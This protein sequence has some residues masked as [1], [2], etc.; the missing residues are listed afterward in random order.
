MSEKISVIIPAYNVEKYIEMCIDSL[1]QQT[2]NDLEIVVIN[3]GSSDKTKE[4]LD[5]Y[6]QN[7]AN[8]RV[9]HTENRGVSCA[10]NTGLNIANGKYVMFL[11]A[12]DYL[13]QNAIEIL[14]Q[15]ALNNDADIVSGLMCAGVSQEP[16]SITDT[17]VEIWSNTEALQKSLEDN[18]F[19]YSSCAKL[20]KRHIVEDVRFVE[21]RKI[22][23]DSYFVFSTFLKNPKVVAREVYLYNYR[24][25]ESSASHAGF[26]EKYFDILYFAKEKYKTIEAQY[27]ELLDKAKNMLVKSNIAMLQCLLNTNDKKYKKDVKDCIREVKKYKRYFIPTYPGDR[28]RFKIIV[29]NL[30]GIF[31]FLYRL[32]YAK[33]IQKA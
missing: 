15:D 23:E 6:S 5:K 32:K 13:A 29:Y 8:I 27:P 33:R 19:T 20:Y 17:N 31:K 14:M 12:D 21:G 1:L 7:H 10:R 16:V 24:V 2:Y 18:P 30:Y 11:D 25:N 26:S 4:I 28:K 22:H 3:D 9:L